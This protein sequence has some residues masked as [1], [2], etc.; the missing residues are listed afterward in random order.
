MFNP[1]GSNKIQHEIISDENANAHKKLKMI[2]VCK[3]I[4]IQTHLRNT[5]QRNAF[6]LGFL[7]ASLDERLP[8]SSICYLRQERPLEL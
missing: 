5:G 1:G 3:H 8:I 6:Q 2:I 4:H 7:S